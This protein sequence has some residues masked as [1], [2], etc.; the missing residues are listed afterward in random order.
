MRKNRD[1]NY[2]NGHWQLAAIQFYCQ[3]FRTKE[4]EIEVIGIRNTQ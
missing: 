1:V 4:K 2:C 3:F